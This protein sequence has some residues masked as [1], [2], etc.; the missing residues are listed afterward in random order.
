M[1]DV[2]T[3]DGE[4]EAFGKQVLVRVSVGKALS[5]NDKHTN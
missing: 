3:D 4:D 1:D 5:R 2:G